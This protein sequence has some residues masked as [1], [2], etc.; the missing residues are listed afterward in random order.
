M[1]MRGAEIVRQLMIYAGKE[2]PVVELVDLS[3][4]VE[5]MLSLLK[6]SVTK[7]AVIKVNLDRDMPAVRASA[8]Q[9]RA[10]C[11]EPDHRKPRTPLEIEME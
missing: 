7:R 2:S 6:A 11:D 1:A 5:G 10:N 8:A 4:A 9:L 3:T